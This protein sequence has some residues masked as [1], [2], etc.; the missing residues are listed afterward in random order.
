MRSYR[1]WVWFTTQQI[2][3][4]TAGTDLPLENSLCDTCHACLTPQTCLKSTPD[5]INSIQWHVISKVWGVELNT[6][7]FYCLIN[8]TMI[9][10]ITQNIKRAIKGLWTPVEAPPTVPQQSGVVFGQPR[11]EY[12]LQSRDVIISKPRPAP[13]RV[14]E[15]TGNQGRDEPFGCSVELR[16]GTWLFFL[17]QGINISTAKDWKLD[18]HED[19]WVFRTAFL[20]GT[21]GLLWILIQALWGVSVY[22]SSLN[23]I[24][25]LPFAGWINKLHLDFFM[26]WHR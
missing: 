22:F 24:L 6:I 15:Q 20:C 14:Q 1:D 5:C 25:V 12:T 17:S 13:G 23:E 19:Y 7:D 9:C 3:T 18:W 11:A 2:Y 21:G 10:V 4:Y 26:T 16:R 8:N